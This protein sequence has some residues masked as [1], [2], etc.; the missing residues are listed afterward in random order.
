MPEPFK[1]Q[2]YYQP[3]SY[4][5]GEGQVYEHL[6]N[7][8]Q[9][10]TDRIQQG[11]DVE[12]KRRGFAE[13]RAAGAEVDAVDMPDGSTISGA[14]FR[15][16][17]NMSHL[18]AVKLD[19]NENLS[20]ITA[21][22]QGDPDVFLSR[23]NSYMNGLLEGTSE[24]V[25][26]LAQEEIAFAAFKIQKSMRASIAQADRDNQAAI[27]E[28]GLEALE[29]EA[30]NAAENGDVESV[31]KSTTQ[32][33]NMLLKSEEAGLL[34]AGESVKRASKLQN[35]MLKNIYLGSF[36]RELEAGRGVQFMAEFHENEQF[37]PK[38]REALSARMV[39]RMN[40]RHKVA[41]E[42]ERLAKADTARRYAKTEREVT[43]SALEGT[44]T[45]EQLTQ[46]LEADTISPSLAR[47]M[48]KIASASGVINDDLA[49]KLDYSLD[50][51]AVSETDI[52]QDDRLTRETRISLVQERRKLEDDAGNWKRTQNGSEATRRIKAEFGM[53][54][55]LIAQLD[56]EKAKRAGNALTELYETIEA[57]P[58][59][60]RAGAAV[61]AA[62]GIISRLK[63]GD[64]SEGLVRVQKTIGALPYQTL[65][66]LD[67]AEE[68]GDVRGHEAK[69]LRKR[70]DSLLRRQSKLESEI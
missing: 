70:L 37:S 17:A 29:I 53:V 43:L 33:Q 8:L 7:K 30:K 58:V 22:S 68:A 52:A 6:A 31:E 34:P 24:E 55:G 69:V 60:Q 49:V 45:T 50:L 28:T 10:F 35:E 48:D 25:K 61:D 16:G 56:P 15:E 5:G 47:T 40:S 36:S 18:A 11:L 9:G 14:A 46:H 39:Q 64:A 19:I 23:T 27:V 32:Y 54:D 44:L 2:T 41:D 12:A 4:R 57:L 38:D 42:T 51:L 67:K 66:D 21:E 65:E 1:R 20:R 59:E 26:P 62:D 63:K 3:G 13:G